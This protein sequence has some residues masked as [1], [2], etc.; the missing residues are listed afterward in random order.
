MDKKSEIKLDLVAVS[1]EAHRGDSID[2]ACKYA[3]AEIISQMREHA[4]TL[5]DD[6]WD[7]LAVLLG[8][9]I[10]RETRG[11]ED[12]IAAYDAARAALRTL[13][14]FGEIEAQVSRDLGRALEPNE[15]AAIIG[16]LDAV[17]RGLVNALRVSAEPDQKPI[18][19]PFEPP[20]PPPTKAVEHDDYCD[21][22]ACGGCNSGD[23]S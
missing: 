13:P 10:T 14:S 11:N 15:C 3:L 2:G 23:E 8:A 20:P 12:P 16:T 7:A 1:L 9:Y 5:P 4:P 21:G 22:F 19:I 6:P 18:G 17:S